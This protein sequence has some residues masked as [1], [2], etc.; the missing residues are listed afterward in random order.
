MRNW[1][2]AVLSVCKGKARALALAWALNDLIGAAG[3][4]T[5]GDAALATLTGLDVRNVGHGLK[6]LERAGLI[7]RERGKV[8]PSGWRQRLIRPT[9]P[10]SFTAPEWPLPDRGDADQPAE[11][12]GKATGG[13]RRVG[14][15]SKP[16]NDKL[17]TP[18][19]GGFAEEQP[20]ERARG[21]ATG[22]SP[23]D[24]TTAPQPARVAPA[25][26]APRDGASSMAD[27]PP[28]PDLPEGEPLPW[29]EALTADIAPTANRKPDL[30]KD[31]HGRPFKRGSEIPIGGTD[32]ACW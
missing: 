19:G 13:K 8:M 4:A 2:A 29:W 20:T 16:P 24:R 31:R 26:G 23:N 1:Q 30:A 21:S 9:I 7:R 15:R 27:E 6:D 17:K 11:S 5:V 12:A 14:D 18:V 10:A 22:P 28:S 25:L 32:D 3:F